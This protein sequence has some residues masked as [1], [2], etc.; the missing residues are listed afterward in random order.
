MGLYLVAARKLNWWSECLAK[1]QA[2]NQAPNTPLK[3][4]VSMP[5]LFQAHPSI[6]RV[7]W[8]FSCRE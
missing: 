8:V 4:F 1:L 5:S 3:L 7:S 2:M 6:E